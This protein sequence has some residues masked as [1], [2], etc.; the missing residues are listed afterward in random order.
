MSMYVGLSH[1]S[2]ATATPQL[3]QVTYFLTEPNFIGDRS[4]A[5]LDYAADSAMQLKILHKTNVLTFNSLG[6]QYKAIQY[7]IDGWLSV[8]VCGM[9]YSC[10]S[11]T[12]ESVLQPLRLVTT[13]YYCH[14]SACTE[15]VELRGSIR[16]HKKEQLA[17]GRGRG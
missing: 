2:V 10:L 5:Q 17:G 13:S 11:H 15:L 12:C 4:L 3:Y 6:L 1:G 16:G 8:C 14:C 7:T 9:Q